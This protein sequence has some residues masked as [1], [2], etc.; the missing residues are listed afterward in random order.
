[1]P[2]KRIPLS[3]VD[4][5]WFRMDRPANHVM[6]TSVVLLATP[7]DFQR[8]KQVFAERLLAFERFRCRVVEQRLPTPTLYWERDP[9]FDIDNHFH[10]VA[11]PNDG[12]KQDL[13]DLISDLATVSIDYARPLW[14]VHVVDHV[15]QGS[16][17]VTRFH[18]CIA[19]GTAMIAVSDLLLD[20]TP[21]AVPTLPKPKSRKRGGGLVNLFLHPTRLVTGPARA[22]SGLVQEGVEAVTHPGHTLEMAQLAAE[23]VGIAALT[24]VKSSDSAGP[25]H[26]HLSGKQRVAFS[27]PVALDQVKEIGRATNSTVNDVLVAAMTGALRHYLAGRGAALDDITMRAVVPVDLR[28]PERALELGNAFGLVFL[29]LPVHKGKS[30]DRLRATKR[31]MDRIK[32]SPEAAVLLNIMA[33]M[34]RTPKQTEDLVSNLFSTKASMVL[35]NVVGPRQMRYL[36]GS[37]IDH[38]LFWVPHPIDMTVGISIFSYK[39]QVTLGVISD[40]GIVPDP[41]VVTD[42]F[43]VEFERLGEA[44]TAPSPSS[45]E[46]A[47][48]AMCA[49][50]TKAGQPCRNRALAG[51]SYCRVHQPKAT[52]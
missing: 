29:E 10:H 51:S 38:M 19:D 4:S 42:R 14:Q 21:D 6:V 2:G 23:G 49:A 33:L 7:V 17:V 47:P 8:V 45:T 46:T 39:G 13:L 43:N 11:L 28:P 37:P 16:A 20:E 24:A 25:L 36:A 9:L 50:T 32:R 52:A 18:H 40:A 15:G 3:P 34:G 12:S 30:L 27:E 41:E 5:V 1:M 31:N 26:G 22:V 48:A 44:I 35:T